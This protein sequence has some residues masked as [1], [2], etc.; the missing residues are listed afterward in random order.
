MTTPREHA[1]SSEGLDDGALL[2][3][4]RM[5]QWR[6]QGRQWWSGVRRLRPMRAFFHFVDVGG[7]V[8]SAGMSYQAVFAVFA[9]LW[10][11][12]GVLGVWLRTRT[13]LL[14]SLIEQ[15][16]LLV[17][18]LLGEDGVVSVSTLLSERSFDWTS[19]AAGVALL[20]V[21]ITWFTGT[22]R[23]IRII[24]GLDVREYRG[25]F[26]LKVRDLI[27]ALL[28]FA[29]L[30]VSAVL[31]V[32]SSNIT[33]W[34]LSVFN[35]SPDNWLIGGFG[36]TARYALLY[37]FDVAVLLGIHVFLAEVRVRRWHLLWG[38]ALGGA[39]LLGLKVLGT[40]LLTGTSS[41]PLLASFAVLIGLLLWFN[42]ICRTLLL[43]A[44]WI[45]TGVDRELG[46]L[47]ESHSRDLH[48]ERYV[49]R[50]RRSTRS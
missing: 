16:N 42:L 7:N 20:W 46:T 2:G 48:E 30:L 29:A 31:T 26:I 33:E 39:V 50:S 21:T 3:S 22:R 44:S 8:L 18:G 28:F 37:V 47:E 36:V 19:I 6:S 1:P 32:F 45:A 25:A 49:Q 4:E 14:A 27:L 17:P 12:F 24:F 40:W 34:L 41:N 10:V 11:G 9:A 13:E 23:S 5:G 38:C 15:I 35:I 43:T